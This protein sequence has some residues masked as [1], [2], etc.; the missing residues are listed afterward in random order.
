MLLIVDNQSQYLRKFK[1]E[2]LD[3]NEIPHLVIEHNEQIDWSVRERIQGLILSGGKG[4]PYE[5]LNLTAN[6]T[7]LMNLAV[8]TVGFCLGHEIIAVAYRGRIKRLPE[9]QAK[10]ELVTLLA[11]NDPIFAGI[12]KTQVLIQKKH[13]FHVPVVPP[14]F[15]VLASSAVCPVEIM[16][17]KHQPIYAFQGHPEVS[18]HDGLK[19]M[20]NLLQLCG[21]P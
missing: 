3:D 13:R 2:Y 21:L 15:E 11:P 12:D 1:R 9:Y 17:H 5:P 20:R 19:M 8:P 10:K 4:N 14:D 18:G 6:Y 7:A 16:R